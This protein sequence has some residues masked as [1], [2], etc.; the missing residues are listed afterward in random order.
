MSINRAVISGNLTR[1]AELRSTATS[2]SVL[3]FSVAVNDRHRNQE[4]GEWEERANFIDCVLFGARAEALKKYLNKGTKVAVDGRLRWSSWEKD[5]KR[6]SK[7]DVVVE[8]LEFMQRNG[9]TTTDDA[10]GA[11]SAHASAS[12]DDAPRVSSFSYASSKGE[13]NCGNEPSVAS[14]ASIV[15]DASTGAEND[16]SSIVSVDTLGLVSPDERDP[17][18]YETE[19]DYY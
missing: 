13:G 4:T 17:D 16:G 7:L 9:S 5:G 12:T 1:D 18:H 11:S 19:V 6:R 14:S 2:L 8:D 10:A 15:A 3:S